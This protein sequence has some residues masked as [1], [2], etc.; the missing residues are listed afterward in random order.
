MFV[1]RLISG[2]VL[3]IILITTICVSGPLL[4]SFLL[5]ISLVGMFELYRAAGIRKGKENALT[6]VAYAGAAVYYLSVFLNLKDYLL[7]VLIGA[8]I[9]LLFV[10]VFTYPKYI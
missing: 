2:I 4:L 6:V 1:T 9:A 3:L 10:Y 7:G 8:L 5:L